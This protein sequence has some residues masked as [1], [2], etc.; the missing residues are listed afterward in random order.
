MASTQEFTACRTA[1]TCGDVCAGAEFDS[2]FFVARLSLHELR[3][4]LVVA[5]F[6]HFT[7]GQA[8]ALEDLGGRLR[9][10]AKALRTFSAARLTLSEVAKCLVPSLLDRLDADQTV[11]SKDDFRRGHVALTTFLIA[12]LSL[13]ESVKSFSVATHKNL[14][15]R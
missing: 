5:R 8:V 9:R 11:S 4:I 6:E 14:V 3:G 12:C 7:A 13:S 2:A 15:T 10:T 1:L